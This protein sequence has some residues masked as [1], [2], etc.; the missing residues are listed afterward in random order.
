MKRFS[1]AQRCC[2]DPGLPF[3]SLL[4]PFIFKFAL[5]IQT[6]LCPLSV[7]ECM[8][9][10]VVKSVLTDPYVGVYTDVYTNLFEVVYT[11]QV[12]YNIRPALVSDPVLATHY[13]QNQTQTNIC[14]V[15]RLIH[16]TAYPP[17]TSCQ[18]L[19]LPACNT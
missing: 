14:F 11:D 19:I 18:V 17:V 2:N 1:H 10:I 7:V 16:V 12:V 8:S 9:L 15:M 13:S 3:S 6:V 4:C 5:S